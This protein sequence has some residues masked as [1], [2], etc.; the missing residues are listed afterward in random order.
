MSRVT[1]EDIAR[2]VRGIDT[3]LGLEDGR[4][5]PET[6]ARAR[7][8]LEKSRSRMDLG[9]DYTVVAFAGSTGSGK[10]SLFNAVAGLDIARVG[11]RRPTTSEPTACVWGDGGEELLSW[12]GVPVQKRTWRES[13]LDGDD[14]ASLHGLVLVDLPDHDSTAPEHRIESDRMVELVDVVFWVV[15][16]QKYADFSLHSHYLSQLTEHASNMVVVLNQIDRLSAEERKACLE[17]LGA[18]LRADG[19]GDARVMAASAVTREGVPQLREVLTGTVAAREAASERLASDLRALAADIRAELGDPLADPTSLPGTERLVDAMIDAAGVPALAQTV[20]DDYLRRAYRQTGYPVLAWMQRGQADPLG[21]GHGAT[22]DEL[23]RAATP[24]TTRTQSARVNLAARE[25]V[26]EAVGSLPAP[27]QQAVAAAEKS[28]TAELTHTLDTAVTAVKLERVTPG[29]WGGARFAQ[30]LFFV[31]TC[32]GVL[33]L[34]VAAVAAL[35][36][37]GEILGSWW[38]WTAPAVC[39][40]VG[41]VGSLITSGLARRARERGAAEAAED[42]RTRLTAAVRQAAA[43][44]YLEPITA[45]LAEHKRVWESLR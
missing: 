15:D 26:A 23:L 40:I 2:L 31:L 37:A 25:L 41:I 22:R 7:T 20:E 18:L 43:G 38:V 30:I 21:A 17:H 11:V 14:E 36:G 45:I 42:V 24:E 5:S 35:V 13:A 9:E 8:L 10:S 1:H 39:L 6:T 32:L 4:I 33:G 44:T 3:A 34:V 28:S 16:P 29:W 27:W 12:L 19:L